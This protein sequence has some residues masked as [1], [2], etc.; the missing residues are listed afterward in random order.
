MDVL[1]AAARMMRS[2]A[3]GRADG[4]QKEHMKECMRSPVVA[5]ALPSCSVLR[6]QARVAAVQQPCE[7]PQMLSVIL[8]RSSAPLY[9]TFQPSSLCQ[10][11]I[12]NLDQNT[13]FE[14]NGYRFITPVHKRALCMDHELEAT[15]TSK[16]QRTCADAVVKEGHPRPE[17][18]ACA[19]TFHET[20]VFNYG[21]AGSE[22][23]LVSGSENSD[24]EWVEQQ[25]PRKSTQRGMCVVAPTQSS[26]ALLNLASSKVGQEMFVLLNTLRVASPDNALYTSYNDHDFSMLLDGAD[27][28][29]WIRLDDT[30][31][32]V[33]A[34]FT[35][36][37]ATI[38]IVQG[39]LVSKTCL[40]QKLLMCHKVAGICTQYCLKAFY[41]RRCELL[42]RDKE[43]SPTIASTC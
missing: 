26:I 11:I 36:R 8:M 9:F 18:H 13:H 34:L 27:T 29:V 37:D 10:G 23:A 41:A 20:E 40:T 15:A 4:N 5:T 31:S 2:E 22:T 3:H 24:D 30:P 17:K 12:H 28:P 19:L 21:D 35:H 42:H 16:K 32:G 33:Y 6:S 43:D 14:H 39:D 7:R 38:F 1:V 25:V